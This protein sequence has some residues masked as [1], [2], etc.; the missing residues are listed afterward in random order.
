MNNGTDVPKPVVESQAE[1]SDEEFDTTIAGL[2]RATGVR[3]LGLQT[4]GRR[5]RTTEAR[6]MARTVGRKERTTTSRPANISNW[7]WPL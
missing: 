3:L 2:G 6:T 7:K 4:V 1:A 5:E